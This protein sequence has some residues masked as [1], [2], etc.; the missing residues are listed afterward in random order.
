[1][2]TSRSK[3]S[4]DLKGR[5]KADAKNLDDQQNA[6]QTL[7][8]LITNFSDVE[9][10]QEI[11]QTKSGLGRVKVGPNGHDTHTVKSLYNSAG[12]RH[13]FG[14]DF[15]PNFNYYI[16]WERAFGRDAIIDRLALGGIDQRGGL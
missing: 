7:N 5:G 3:F 14:D 6:I 10:P 9:V 16:G 1:L 11:S 15:S 13:E 2:H 4:R 12:F 8:S